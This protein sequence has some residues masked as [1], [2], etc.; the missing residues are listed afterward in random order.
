MNSN[1]NGFDRQW[2]NDP[3]EP[4]TFLCIEK[5]FPLFSL[6]EYKAVI[7]AIK[8]RLAT[9]KT[10]SRSL[11]NLDERMLNIDNQEVYAIEI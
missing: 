4:C 1:S 9:P 10:F 8:K 5:N 7:D 2:S 3:I 6:Y 11:L